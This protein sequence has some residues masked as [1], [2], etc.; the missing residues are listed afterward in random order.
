MLTVFLIHFYFSLV[1][2]S[3]FVRVYVFG[4]RA[5]AHT[6]EQNWKV[7]EDHAPSARW[8]V[9]TLI[10]MLGIAGGDCDR[11]VPSAAVVYVSQ[12]EDLHAY[13]AHKTFR[14]VQVGWLVAWVGEHD[15]CF[16]L[17]VGG[18]CILDGRP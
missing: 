8:R 5:R 18:C 17:L 16:G 7:V 1:L 11:S 14:M 10:S 2:S 12:N 3:V 15:G 6:H 4:T 13:A 9:D